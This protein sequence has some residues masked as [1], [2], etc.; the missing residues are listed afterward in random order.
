M[1]K[2]FTLAIISMIASLMFAQIPFT[3]KKSVEK[4]SAI[5]KVETVAR[6][7]M[8][9]QLKFKNPAEKYMQ[10]AP[11]A[12]VL[13]KGIAKAESDVTELEA[14]EYSA[15]YYASDGDWFCV[16]TTAIGP[17][18]FD[19]VT[20][21]PSPLNGTY[22]LA[23]MDEGYSWAGTQ[24]MGWTYTDATFTVNADASQVDAYVTLDSGEEVHVSYTKP[25]IPE[26]TSYKTYEFSAEETDL[27]D[28]TASNGVFQIQGENA[29]GQYVSIAIY[30]DQLEGTYTIDD[31]YLTYCVIY[32][33]EDDMTGV[34]PFALNATVTAEGATVIFDAYD[35]CEYTLKFTFPE[36]EPVEEIDLG[37]D[38]AFVTRDANGIITAVDAEPRVYMRSTDAFYAYVSSQQQKYA[39]Q[40]GSVNVV[41]DGDIWY[42]KDIIC[43]IG[44][45][46]WVKGRLS[47]DG[48]KL[49]VPAN[50]KIYWV[51]D[52]GYGM[53]VN[54]GSTPGTWKKS[55]ANI[56]YTVGENTLTLDNAHAAVE[57]GY[58]SFSDNVLGAF[59][60]DDDTF[61][62]YGEWSTVLTYDPNYVAPSTDPV[63]LPDG[64]NV[65]N[66]YMSA[67]SVGQT[68]NTTIKDQVV[69]VAFVG[70]EFYVKGIFKSLFPNAWI[71]GT[72]SGSTITFADAQYLGKDSYGD[73][74]WAQ[75]LD[76]ALGQLSGDYTATYDA[77]AKT[78]TLNNG[79][80]ANCDVTRIYYDAYYQDV[81]FYAELP[82][83]KL[84]FS[85]DG[86]KSQLPDGVTATSLGSDRGSSPKLNFS[87]KNG[88]LVINFEQASSVVLVYNV[89][90]SSNNNRGLTFNVQES[91]DGVNY[92]TVNSH[93]T[94]N[95]TTTA[96]THVVTLSEGA[97]YV[98]FVLA[99][100]GSGNVYLG[101]I[102]LFSGYTRNVTSGDFGTIC[103]PYAVAADGITGAQFSSV[104]D[105]DGDVL[106]LAPVTSLEAG[107][108]YIFKASA[109]T[110]ACAYSGEAVA[111]PAEDDYL[112]GVFADTQAPV[113]AY[114]MQKNDGVL[115][116]YQVDDVQ[117]TVKANRAYLTVEGAE[118]RAFFFEGQETAISSV[119]AN[120]NANKAIYNLAGQRVNKA[121]K[122]IFIINGKKV[123]K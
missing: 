100:R 33:S 48:T 81:K 114:V 5:T 10:V 19:I 53:T 77:A 22:T 29:A 120:D 101:A 72:I 71:K 34:K 14:T 17:F 111:E 7:A 110:I 21:D 112:T 44:T 107:K 61:A 64:A 50:Q 98:K 89:A 57:G 52:E 13:K 39:Y 79:L 62:G 91:A 54:Y 25:E 121:E 67:T 46:T 28:M 104:E 60:T 123:I 49:L 38:A 32:T 92:T 78:I 56:S 113:G 65:E 36:P 20:N 116:F 102:K 83:A 109:A 90:C 68:S 12:N 88:N 82:K 8:G 69:S 4:M 96:Q 86:G 103:L 97:C 1:K 70:D 2:L 59:W 18:R 118:A 27:N 106:T 24:S 75:G 73:D 51:D 43:N 122:G 23:Q 9:K 26:I 55:N 45:G 95:L 11:K 84:P 63:V 94:G 41:V 76:E 47:E 108:P 87:T 6:K 66:W 42:I 3:A 117:P 74:T 31:A 35:G 105:I 40:S 80:L 119:E 16:L 37:P 58:I 115:G 15:E 85:F 30:S 99:A 93:A